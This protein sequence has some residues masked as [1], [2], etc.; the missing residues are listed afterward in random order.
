[1]KKY[2]RETFY[3][4]INNMI[5]QYTVNDKKEFWKLIRFV[6]KTGGT[7]NAIPPLINPDTDSIEI[8]DKCKADVLNKYFS[9]I[10]TID[11]SNVEL[12]DF[13]SRTDEKLSDVKFDQE[14]II[15]ILLSL[16]VNKAVGIDSISHHMLRNTAHSVSLP[17]MILFKRC[18]KLQT[19]RITQYG[20]RGLRAFDS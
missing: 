18:I 14:D 1:M 7:Y 11:D 9:D 12:P 8:D 17:L 6:T 3:L 10:S 5:D 13:N 20:R 16:N 15:D 4:D 2:A 19:Y